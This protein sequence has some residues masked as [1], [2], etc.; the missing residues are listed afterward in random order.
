MDAFPAFIPLFDKTVIVA[1]EGEAA[2]AK[3]RLFDGSPA[4]LVRLSL[5]A[6]A[7]EGALAGA[8]LVFIA[9]PPDVAEALAA[10]ARAAGALVNVVDAP[11]LGD[12][13]TPSIVDRGRVVGAIGTDGC[14]PVMAVRLRQALETL[15]PERLGDLARLMG[16]MREPARARFADMGRRR[17]WLR[18]LIEGEAGRA[19]LDGRMQEARMLA[20][21][22]LAEAPD[23]LTGA[24]SLIAA[25]RR[26]DA[27]TLGE[28]RR[29]GDADTV[30]I[31]GEVSAAVVALARRD[32]PRLP[33]EA[34]EA[35]GVLERVEAG[36]QV[37]VLCPAADARRLRDALGLGP[38][39]EE[40]RDALFD[41]EP[42]A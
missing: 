9:G 34:V 30:V 38:D 24:V 15:W 5:E 33:W 41:P 32:A 40:G 13:T 17:T 36:E 39:A 1:G 26:P 31:A 35:P 6:A 2:D 10:R 12:F 14:A 4:R 3:A 19:A 11:A 20:Q 27:L 37:A 42:D 16:E 7:A 28:A 22:A 29:L 23:R 21:A 25:P 18:S 8:A